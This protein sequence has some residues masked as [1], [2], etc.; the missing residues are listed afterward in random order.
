MYVEFF[1]LN[2]RVFLLHIL[3][4]IGTVFKLFTVNYKVKKNI[5]SFLI[6]LLSVFSIAGCAEHHY[7]HE[8][9]QHSDRYYHH[10]RRSPRVDIDIH[11]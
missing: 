9:H 1:S 7:Y 2:Y 3:K 4:V 8:N 6:V 11:N 10:H 5:F